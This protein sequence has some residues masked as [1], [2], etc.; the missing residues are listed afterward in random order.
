MA[1]FDWVCSAM[2]VKDEINVPIALGAF[3]EKGAMT[4]LVLSLCM[5]G[6][7]HDSPSSVP[8]YGW[9]VP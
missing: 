3:R 9:V 2:T 7:C 1:D 8:L 4:V 6:W 5:G